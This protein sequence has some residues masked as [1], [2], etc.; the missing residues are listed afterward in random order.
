MYEYKSQEELY[1]GLVPAMNVKMTMFKK[2]HYDDIT[3][4]DIWNYLKSNKWINC[5]DLTLGEMVHDIIHVDHS[6]IV[7]YIKNKKD[8]M[9]GNV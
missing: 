5:V 8:S 7:R 9:E 1:Q 3:R 2:S 4:E 6:D